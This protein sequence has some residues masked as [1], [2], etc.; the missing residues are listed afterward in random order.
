MPTCLLMNTPPDIIRHDIIWIDVSLPLQIISFTMGRYEYI[1]EY[2]TRYDLYWCNVDVI[3]HFPTKRLD[4][5]CTGMSFMVWIARE[6]QMVPTCLLMNKPLD[7]IHHDELWND[8]VLWLERIGP[9]VSRYELQVIN[10]DGIIK[11]HRYTWIHNS[12]WFVLM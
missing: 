5:Q 7:M 11:W 2:T 10:H 3:W 6:N 1:R 8:I 9:T 12:I 4:P